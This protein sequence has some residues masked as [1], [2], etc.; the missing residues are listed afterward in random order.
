MG[1]PNVHFR[2]NILATF[3]VLEAAIDAGMRQ[4]LF[5]SSSTVY[6]DATRLPTPEDY[7]PLE[8]ISVYGAC[9]LASESLIAAYCHIY[10]IR[11]LVF[12]LA[13][14]VGSRA[15]QG[16]VVDFV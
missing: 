11:G 4:F 13:N 8:P 6:G 16:V 14:I 2:E 1:D 5:T 12:R 3:R 15:K 10:K 7:A 9:K